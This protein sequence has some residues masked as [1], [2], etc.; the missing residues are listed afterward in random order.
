MPTNEERLSGLERLREQL[1]LGGGQQR[2][3]AQHARE[4][5]TAR[6]RI[7]MLLDDG[8]FEEVDQLVLLAGTEFNPVKVHAEAVVTGWGKID[9]RPVYVFSQDFTVVGGSLSAPMGDKGVKIMDL[10]MKNGAPG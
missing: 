3:D 4:K 9:G 10:A 6:E 8:S 1:R 2:V 7:H 5:L